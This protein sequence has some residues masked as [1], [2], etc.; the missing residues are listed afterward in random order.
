M[1]D[2]KTKGP[3]SL[4]RERERELERTRRAYASSRSVAWAADRRAMG[5]RG[6]E[7]ET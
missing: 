3:L 2:P 4:R 7:Q 1:D 6:P 5:T